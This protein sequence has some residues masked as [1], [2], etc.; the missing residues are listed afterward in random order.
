MSKDTQLVLQQG[1]RNLLNL[2]RETENF[3]SPIE[4]KFNLPNKKI[5]LCNFESKLFLFGLN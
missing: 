5:L 2:P 1:T 3:R 4:P